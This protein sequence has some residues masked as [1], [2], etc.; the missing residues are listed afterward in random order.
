M[1]LVAGGSWLELTTFVFLVFI[2]VVG[3]LEL[4]EFDRSV[5]ERLVAVQA[6]PG[7]LIDSRCRHFRIVLYVVEQRAMAGFAGNLFVFASA[8]RLGNV[9]VAGL[10]ADIAL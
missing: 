7:R 10:A 2:E 1:A 6:I 9:L 3:Q 5:D 4:G 8:H